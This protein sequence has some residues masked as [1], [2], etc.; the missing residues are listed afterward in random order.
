V[1]VLVRVVGQDAK[2]ARPD[3]LQE[4]V[5]REFGVAGV[6]QGRGEGPG[7]ADALVEL[8]DGEQPGVAGELAR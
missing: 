4:R 2:D 8:A 7:Q 3:H 1:V 6:V 5:L